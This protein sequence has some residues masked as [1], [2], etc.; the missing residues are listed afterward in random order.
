[1]SLP[2]DIE[3][4]RLRT[5][6]FIRTVVIPA[7][8]APG[9]RLKEAD[10]TRLQDAAKAAGVYAPH[11]P[12]EY[13]G[14]GVPLR[15]WSPI[16]QEAGY[17]LI[18]PT[19]LNCQAPD[20][21]NMHM[22][23]L[24]GTEAQKE[25]YLRPLVS[26]AARSC[27]GMTEPHP[28]AGSDPAALRSSAAKVDGG[29]VITGHKR[30]T[31]GANNATFCIAMVRTPALEATPTSAAAQAGATMLLVDMDAPGVRI[32]EQISTMDRAIGGGHPHLHFEDV[33]VPDTAVLGAPGEGFRYAQVRLGPAR[34]THCMRW[35]GLARRAMDI[36]L[37]RANTREMFGAAL[38]E[39][40]IAQDM[41]AL[42]VMDLETSDAIITKTAGLLESDARAGSALSSVAKAHT[43]EAVY[44]VI[45]RSLQL[46][47]GDGVSDRLPLA[48]YLNEVRAFRIYDGSNETHKWAIARRASSARRREVAS[49][50]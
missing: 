17:S 7:E 19:V 34:L 44:R 21:G 8:P 49:A 46:C 9:E 13:G 23:E 25:Q 29:W 26:G 43:S 30:F 42:N 18:G 12:R 16:F 10:R 5:R 28:G 33:F 2:S 50:R 37:D 15:Y 6:D 47:G 32:G 40:G 31:S 48:S 36:A 3:D 27:F 35:L 45:D 4:L 38:H 41:L 14:Q 20:E 1:M 22:L 39:L 24:I 11:A